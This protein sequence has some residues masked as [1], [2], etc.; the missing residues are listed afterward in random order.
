MALAVAEAHRIL[1]P[2]GAILDIHPRAAPR[3]LEH[4]QSRTPGMPDTRSAKAFN[5]LPLGDLA[6]DDFVQDLLAAS[7]TLAVAQGFSMAASVNFEFRYF[8]DTLGEL[9][10]YLDDNDELELASN[11]L[12]EHA[13]HAFRRSSTPS[14]LVMA[15]PV[16]VNRLEKL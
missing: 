16:V 7:N 1:R 13:L 3:R 11:D 6:P 9:T 4:W 2:R 15:Q 12:L 14:L 10:G 8:F 5:A